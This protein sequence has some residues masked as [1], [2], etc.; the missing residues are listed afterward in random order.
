MKTSIILLTYN[1]LSFTRKC[2]DS[3]RTNT[4]PNDYEIIVVDNGSTDGTVEWLRAQSDLQVIYN[5]DNAGFPKG[6]NQG[7]AL[8]KGDNLLLLNNDTIVTP[9]WLGQLLS[10]LYSDDWIG[11]VG[12]VTNAAAYYSALQVPYQ[13][14]ED[15][16]PFAEQYNRTDPSKWEERLK[17]V[18]FCLLIKRE[19]Y[20]AVGDL[21]ERFSPGNF[22]DDDYSLRIRQAGYRLM[23]S[24]DTFIHHEGSASFREDPQSFYALMQ[25]NSRKFA[26]KWGFSPDYSLGIRHDILQCLEEPEAEPIRVLEVGCACGATLLELKNW[27]PNAELHGIELNPHAAA[28]ASRF[29]NVRSENIESIDIELPHEYFD[30]II[31]ADVLEHLV[32]PWN[33]LRTVMPYLKENGKV[34]ASIPNVAHYSVIR[35]LLKGYWTYTD[36]GLLDVTHLRFF[37]REGIGRLFFGTGFQAL[38]FRVN[39]LQPSRE[40]EEWMDAMERLVGNDMKEEWKVYQYIVKAYKKQPAPDTSR[41]EVIIQLRKLVRRIEWEIDPEE[42]SA[43]LVEMYRNRE[44]EVKDMANILEQDVVFPFKTAQK[45]T[46]ILMNHGLFPSKEELLGKLSKGNR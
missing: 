37:T 20:E 43:E 21:D 46:E 14:L 31:F 11:G 23:L 35:D 36:K 4:P 26:Q 40:D 27:Y 3:I 29:A 16:I 10:C 34:L 13:T 25:T 17:L 18:G 24:T 39:I 42:S 15:M 38:Q 1:G 6:C 12:P 44:I 9:R 41:S 30:Y 19:V 33:V 8:A 45:I 2:I 5:K 7:M 28:I 22:E 32:E